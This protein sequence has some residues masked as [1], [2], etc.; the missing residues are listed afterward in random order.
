MA[1][2]AAGCWVCKPIRQSARTVQAAAAAYHCQVYFAR[3]FRTVGGGRS[4]ES[5]KAIVYK[6]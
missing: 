5:E 3:Q 1:Y 4:A 2:H 6:W